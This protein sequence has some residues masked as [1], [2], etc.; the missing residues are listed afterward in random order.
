MN[1][2]SISPY[3]DKPSSINRL[4]GLAGPMPAP[5]RRRMRY[6]I[7]GSNNKISAR[8]PPD[9]HNRTFHLGLKGLSVEQDSGRSGGAW[10]PTVQP[11]AA[12]VVERCRDYG[13]AEQ[14]LGG[15]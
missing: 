5:C 13:P 7:R 2:G 8:F 10:Q 14:K 9:T 15:L 4:L 12:V 6:L 3:E 11:G 1:R